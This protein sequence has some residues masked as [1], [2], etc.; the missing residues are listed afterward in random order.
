MQKHMFRKIIFLFPILLIGFYATIHPVFILPPERNSTAE[1][2]GQALGTSIGIIAQRIA[3]NKVWEEQARQ[4]R[5]A[6]LNSFASAIKQPK[7][8]ELIGKTQK[9]SHDVLLI[10]LIAILL[11][12][13][14]FKNNLKTFFKK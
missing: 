1:Q 13:F 10:L 8:Q 11:A 14:Y 12:L 2:L 7:L 4:I 5:K 3:A 9:Q 6:Y